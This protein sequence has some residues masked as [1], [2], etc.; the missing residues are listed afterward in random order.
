MDAGFRHRSKAAQGASVIQ[1]VELK[2]L[3]AKGRR[4]E[5]HD[6]VSVCR[7]CSGTVPL[8][9]HCAFAREGKRCFL[10]GTEDEWAAEVAAGGERAKAAVRLNC[11]SSGAIRFPLA[12]QLAEAIGARLICLRTLLEGF[13]VSRISHDQDAQIGK[14][15]KI[16][17]WARE[18]LDRSH[19]AK[20]LKKNMAKYAKGNGDR[21]T[22]NFANAAV[23]SRQVWLDTGGEGNEYV[24]AEAF[25]EM[26]HHLAFHLQGNHEFCSAECKGADDFTLA[27][28]DPDGEMLDDA[29]AGGPDIFAEATGGGGDNDEGEEYAVVTASSPGARGEAPLTGEGGDGAPEGREESPSA[30]EDGDGAPREREE[31]SPVGEGSDDDSGEGLGNVGGGTEESPGQASGAAQGGGG[32]SRRR[33]AGQGYPKSE[34]GKV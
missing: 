3:S 32:R 23:R 20:N 8:A 25:I 16:M 28:G 29:P 15:Y 6:L 13:W 34:P 11:Y 27:D 14:L 22:R 12:A 21:T 19:I 7:R 4:T 31:A 33:H 18:C 9:M 5:V 26:F 24:W 1:S 17:Y 30:R 2:E 10:H